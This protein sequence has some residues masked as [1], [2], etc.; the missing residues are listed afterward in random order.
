MMRIFKPEAQFLV[1]LSAFLIGLALF[2]TFFLGTVAPI[3]YAQ[4]DY[5]P[6]YFGLQAAFDRQNPYSDAVTHH[7]QQLEFAD[8]P[9]ATPEQLAAANT[10]YEQPFAYPLAPSLM[11]TPLILLLSPEQSV[12]V[13]RFINLAMYLL[14]VPMLFAAF[15]F[16]RKAVKNGS[17][18]A[19]N[20]LLITVL[21]V[22]A[23]GPMLKVFWP[24]VQPS[25]VEIFLVAA[26]IFC[27]ARK[28]YGWAG[29]LTFLIQFKPQTGAIFLL[30]LAFFGLLVAEARWHLLKGFLLT[31]L[32]LTALAFWLDPT[33][34]TDWLESLRKL[35]GYS[36]VYAINML[37]KFGLVIG[38]PLAL[39]LI[40][41][42][43]WAWFGAV[44][45]SNQSNLNKYGYFRGQAWAIA[46]IVELAIIPRTG[47]Y[48][49]IFC[50]VPLFFSLLY[51]LDYMKIGIYRLIVAAILLALFICSTLYLLIDRNTVF[52]ITLLVAALI[53]ITTILHYFYIKPLQQER[54]DVISNLSKNL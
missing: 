3:S 22:V 48:D 52:V 47:N 16:E 18:A 12:A 42:N 23:G 28:Y 11:F 21:I 19:F 7:I 45:A 49:L 39:V 44:K 14:S 40:G 38:I 20:L 33:W 46:T 26:I 34:I 8:D 5:S 13:M 54:P 30:D 10:T 41:L 25:G 53:I 32:P 31:A 50:Y 29:A 6:T 51:F 4:T 15:G 35:S 36:S 43:F 24:I 17:R 9:T 37:A 27:F 2:L 1:V